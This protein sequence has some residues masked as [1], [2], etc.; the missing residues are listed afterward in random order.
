MAKFLVE[1]D[2]WH[3]GNRWKAGEVVE[4]DGDL[5]S[6]PRHLSP[7][8]K[9]EA[10]EKAAAKAARTAIKATLLKDVRMPA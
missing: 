1:R 4:I 5:K 10:L 2:C 7:L 8:T 9:M 6:L 3:N